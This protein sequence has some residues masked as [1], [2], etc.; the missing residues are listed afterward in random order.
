MAI[1]FSIRYF[2]IPIEAGNQFSTFYPAVALSFFI[3]GA[4]P[5]ILSIIISAIISY[6][7]FFPPYQTFEFNNETILPVAIFVLTSFVFGYLIAKMR[8]FRAKSIEFDQSLLSK[9]P[10]FYEDTLKLAV[11]DAKI[12]FWR[13]NILDDAVLLSDVASDYYGLP[14]QTKALTYEEFISAIVPEDREWVVKSRQNTFITHGD[15]R[16]EFRVF[17]PDG[18]THWVSSIGRP[19]FSPNGIIERMDF[20]MLDIADRKNFQHEIREIRLNVDKLADE[21]TVILRKANE[22]LA[23]ISRLDVLTGLANRLAINEALHSEYALMKRYEHTYS[24][25]MLD[26]DFFKKVNDT[27]GHQIG[28][29]VLQ[30]LAKTLKSNLRENDLSGRFG[31]EEFLVLLP[32]LDTTQAKKVAE[33]LRAAIEA[34]PHP[35]A[36]VFTVSIGVATASADQQ[37]EN[38]IV[39][40][41]DR[42]L[43]IAKNAGRNR[44]SA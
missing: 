40:E 11:H 15:F 24:I 20:I 7:F 10:S 2:L 1:A 30:L 31:G 6:Y 3:G 27:Y 16:A 12:G 34:A 33:K 4:G 41:A 22:E 9:I 13:W 5:G 43:Y 25:L 18:S 36:G 21:K 17:W 26:I 23:K 37:D 14:H 8:E 28:D 29:E 35:V 44:V 38:A 32:T 19:H 42:Q 39:M